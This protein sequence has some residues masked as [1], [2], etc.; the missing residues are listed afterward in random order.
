VETT[1]FSNKKIQVADAASTSIA[2]SSNYSPEIVFFVQSYFNF[3]GN[4]ISSIHRQD[5]TLF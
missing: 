5:V 4:P 3:A 1:K 2:A